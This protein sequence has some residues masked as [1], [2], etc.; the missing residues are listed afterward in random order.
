MSAS[1]HR[2]VFVADFTP[3]E[4]RVSVSEDGKV[5]VSE[6]QRLGMPSPAH[7]VEAMA[8]GAS[9]SSRL[10]WLKLLSVAPGSTV[11]TYDAAET[12]AYMDCLRDVA[13]PDR[14][15]S[16][17][18]KAAL[19]TGA[20]RGSIGSELVRALLMGGCRVLVTTSSFS[21]KTTTFYR[22]MFEECGASGSS[23][24]VVPFN[25]ASK[26]DVGRLVDYMYVVDCT[27]V[28]RR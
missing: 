18:G 4:P 12:A 27:L 11:R 8:A 2:P 25:G 1:S 26:Q 28:A 9:A 24:T 23:L 10:P 6:E 14:G 16:F 13:A 22:S 7:Y 5:H 20:G 3:T 19:V 15:V 21:R 17:A